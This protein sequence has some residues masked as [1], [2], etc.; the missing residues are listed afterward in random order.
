MKSIDVEDW[1]AHKLMAHPTRSEWNVE[2]FAKVGRI[3][4]NRALL[5]AKGG[6]LI[7]RP[8]RHLL[9]VMRKLQ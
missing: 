7:T 8:I 1:S 6:S 2:S 9:K 3:F 5:E 4:R